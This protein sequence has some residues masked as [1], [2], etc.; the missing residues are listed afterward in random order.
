MRYRL[1]GHIGIMVGVALFAGQLFHHPSDRMYIYPPDAQEDAE[2]EENQTLGSQM[3][4][5]GCSIPHKTVATEVSEVEARKLREDAGYASEGVSGGII[6][7]FVETGSCSLEKKPDDP[8][9]R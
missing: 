9:K 2:P 4:V 6:V 8:I 3:I 1:I 7:E 5:D